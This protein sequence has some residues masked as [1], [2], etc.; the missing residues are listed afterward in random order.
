MWGAILAMGASGVRMGVG[1][2]CG[3]GHVDMWTCGHGLRLC[4]MCRCGVGVVCWCCVL[5]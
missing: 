5:V 2:G 3:V 4:P 1:V